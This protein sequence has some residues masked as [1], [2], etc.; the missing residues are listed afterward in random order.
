MPLYGG[1]RWEEGTLGVCP[2]CGL[3]FLKRNSVQKYCD[4]KVCK[5]ARVRK[6]VREFRARRKQNNSH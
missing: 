6:N 3:F 4:S 2:N 1:D 5:N